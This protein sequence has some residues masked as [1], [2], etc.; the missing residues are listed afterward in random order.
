[1]N[2]IAMILTVANA[3]CSDPI[4]SISEI[5]CAIR[6]VDKQQ[7]YFVGIEKDEFTMGIALHAPRNPANDVPQ[8]SGRVKNC[9]S[10]TFKC[11]SIAEIVFA[12]PKGTEQA[13]EYLAGPRISIERL[14]NGGWRG[15][16]KCSAIT[17]E[18]CVWRADASK[19]VEAYQ[20]DVSPTGILTSVKT[21]H[22]KD[23]GQPLNNQDLILVS[24]IGLKLD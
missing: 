3:S 12:I 2:L 16:A 24:K 10:R 11:R 17:R 21:Q 14:A 19:L 13:A 8:V 4:Y 22:W 7:S 5:P 6:Y 15:S 1:M 20:Y 23:S 18:G 9:S